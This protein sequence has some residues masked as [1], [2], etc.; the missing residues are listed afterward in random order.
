MPGVGRVDRERERD[1]C[2]GERRAERRARDAAADQEEQPDAQQVE[3][4]GRGVRRRERVPAS[5]PRQHELEG[6]VGQIEQRPVRVAVLVVGREGTPQI[7]SVGE[8]VGTDHARV[9]DVDHVAVGRVQADAESDEKERGDRQPAPR[10]VEPQRLG[11]CRRAPEPDPQQPRQQIAEQRVAERDRQIQARVVEERERR[12][13]A[14]ERQQIRVQPAKWSPHVEERQHEEHAQ[15]HP[16]P[17]RVDRLAEGPRITASHRPRD[18]KAGPRLRHEPG[19]GVDVGLS[20]P[21]DRLARP[22][23]GVHVDDPVP[24]LELRADGR[25]RMLAPHAGDRRDAERGGLGLGRR[26]PVAGCRRSDRR[27]RAGR[28][29]PSGRQDEKEC[30]RRG[31]AQRPNVHSLFATKLSGVTATIAIAWAGSSPT[32]SSSTRTVSSPSPTTNA[33]TLTIRNRGA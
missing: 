16:D 7:A 30:D 10:D 27:L 31:A 29:R 3:E 11:R 23:L 32:P 26:D 33:M 18:L 28:R 1:P 6:H 17:R 24:V 15:R 13:E 14:D 21:V 5:V 19:R 2:V 8:L 12:A 9:A 25:P 22:R 20:E 4:A